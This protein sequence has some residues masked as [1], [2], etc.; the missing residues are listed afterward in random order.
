MKRILTPALLAFVLSNGSAFGA[1]KGS[2]PELTSELKSLESGGFGTARNEKL[3]VV[4]DRH[5][6]LTNAF[7][8]MAGIGKDLNSNIYLSTDETT[9]AARYHINN[10]FF[11]QIDGAQVNSALTES[12]ERAW[13][14]DGIYPDTSFVN[15]RYGASMGLN[16]MYGKVRVT[17]NF[18]FYFDQFL[19]L[20]IG[21]IEQSNGLTDSS[22]PTIT[23][24]AGL[25]F[26]IGD[27]VSLIVGA[28]DTYF[29]EKRRS[30]S[31]KVHQVVA[32]S[33]VGV[34]LGGKAL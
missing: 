13:R 32:Y 14:N 9:F 34:L 2:A 30:S 29:E 28:R 20:G 4:Q 33:G 3:Y 5:V 22:D 31:S 7:T 15:R 26:G 24:E 21:R 23:A 25:S 19:T 18:V 10:F 8:V 17:K 6:D 1:E 16:L 11:A 12:G 27:M